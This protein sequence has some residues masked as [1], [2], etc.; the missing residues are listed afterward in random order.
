MDMR[1]IIIVTVA[2]MSAIVTAVS[3]Q[4]PVGDTTAICSEHDY[5]HDT[6]Y[7]IGW[8]KFPN[9]QH[10]P[11][12]VYSIFQCLYYENYTSAHDGQWEFEYPGFV[13]NGDVGRHITGIEY[14]APL[15]DVKIIGLAAC[16]YLTI[17]PF[18]LNGINGKYSSWQNWIADT[19]ILF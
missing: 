9:G 7:R 14:I 17:N 5:I 10:L 18:T 19:A 3:A 2:M 13:V 12:P 16:P 15:S 4:R 8:V 11:D 6:I 1:K